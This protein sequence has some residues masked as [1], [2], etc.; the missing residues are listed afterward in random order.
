MTAKNALSS[1]IGT[2]GCRHPGTAGAPV[3]IGA[4]AAIF[5]LIDAVLFRPFDIRKWLVLG[6]GYLGMKL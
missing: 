2:A 5:S 6:M 4:N 1:W 3:T